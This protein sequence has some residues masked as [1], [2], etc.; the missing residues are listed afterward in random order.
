MKRY[1]IEQLEENDHQNWLITRKM[2]DAATSRKLCLQYYHQVNRWP[3]E[4]AFV[5][6]YKRHKKRYRR[7]LEE[8][9]QE[10][11]NNDV[12]K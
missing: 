7:L 3:N 2:S 8:Y 5:D 1:T 11:I 9:R 4:R 6:E 10:R 12:N